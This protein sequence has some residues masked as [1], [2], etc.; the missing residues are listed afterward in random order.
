MQRSPK[1]T[2]RKMCIIDPQPIHHGFQPYIPVR[3][4][5]IKF[6]HAGHFA[7]LAAQDLTAATF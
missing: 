3:N 6:V 4:K 1:R 7:F 5:R 2:V